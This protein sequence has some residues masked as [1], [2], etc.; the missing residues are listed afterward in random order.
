MTNSRIAIWR[1]TPFK[2]ALCAAYSD[3]VI[4][5]KQLHALVDRFDRIPPP[6]LIDRH[7]WPIEKFKGKPVK[8]LVRV[9]VQ[10]LRKII[11]CKTP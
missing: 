4:D 10:N 7:G 9:V 6:W 8:S 5:S 1:R 11:P 2:R 3:G